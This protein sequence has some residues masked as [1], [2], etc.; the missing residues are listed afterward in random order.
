MH[1]SNL[2]FNTDP[3]TQALFK[4]Y[5]LINSFFINLEIFSHQAYVFF[6]IKSAK[7]RIGRH[8]S[9]LNHGA[10]ESIFWVK[11]NAREIMNRVPS[12]CQ[13]VGVQNTIKQRRFNY[14]PHFKIVI[15]QI[16]NFKFFFRIGNFHEYLF[17]VRPKP[18]VRCER[19]IGI[20]PLSQLV[21]HLAD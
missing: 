1:S 11:H 13:I 15:H 21:S 4:L 12:I 20:V 2:I 16:Q 5:R 18:L 9:V 3:S 19:M 10:P 6:R 7:N 8:P 17:S 14:R